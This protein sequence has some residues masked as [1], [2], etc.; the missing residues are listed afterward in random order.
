MKQER[1]ELDVNRIMNQLGIRLRE[2]GPA[3]VHPESQPGRFTASEDR[4]ASGAAGTSP[5]RD[6]RPDKPRPRSVFGRPYSA[7]TLGNR[8]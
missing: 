3:E 5:A 8:S 1:T 7:K 4:S 2:G 6:W